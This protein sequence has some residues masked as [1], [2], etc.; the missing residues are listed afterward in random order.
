MVLAAALFVAAC[1]APSS[2]SPAREDA[3]RSHFCIDDV[4][5]PNQPGMNSARTTPP[6][7]SDINWLT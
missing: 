4:S 5:M 6:P 2:L 7:V 1:A 3:D